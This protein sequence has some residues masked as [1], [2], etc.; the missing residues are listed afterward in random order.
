MRVTFSSF[1]RSSGCPK[2]LLR[3]LQDNGGSVSKYSISISCL[4]GALIKIF[5]E[6]FIPEDQLLLLPPNVA[7]FVA[8][9]SR[10]RIFSELVDELDLSPLRS[11]FKGGG[12]P[13]YDPVMLYKVLIYV[14]SEGS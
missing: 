14:L 3:P 9:D 7:D 6:P 12:A 4:E 11:A 5:K 13:A 8:E 1:P 2:S 10:V